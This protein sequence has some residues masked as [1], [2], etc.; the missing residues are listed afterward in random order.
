[1]KKQTN[2]F[3][4][5]TMKAIN[6]TKTSEVNSNNYFDTLCQGFHGGSFYGLEYILED[7]FQNTTVKPSISVRPTVDWFGLYH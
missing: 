1:M 7:F 6:E 2:S 5:T 3:K 4:V